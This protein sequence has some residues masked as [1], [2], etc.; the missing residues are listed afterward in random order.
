VKPRTHFPELSLQE[1]SFILSTNL[2]M[3][4]S[5]SFPNILLEKMVNDLGVNTNTLLVNSL[6]IHSVV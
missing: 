2:N 6:T 5:H 3:R 4:L 1:I